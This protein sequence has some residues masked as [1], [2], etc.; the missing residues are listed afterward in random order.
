MTGSRQLLWL[1]GRNFRKSGTLGVVMLLSWQSGLAFERPPAGQVTGWGSTFISKVERGTGITN[2]ASG[3]THSLAITSRGTVACWG[4]NFNDYGYAILP[5][6]LSNVVAVG[7]GQYHS[8]A[9]RS[10]GTVV[11]WGANNDGQLMVP[12][13]LSNVVAI[14]VGA[15]DCLALKADGTVAAWGYSPD[16]TPPSG[17]S[18]V[19]AVA[20]GGLHSL[21]LLGDGTVTGWESVLTARRLCR[22]G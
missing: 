2:I 8:V 22:M 20:A 13:G 10:D 19:V 3:W 9:L 18:N 16:S 21:A 6:G 5:E 17:L 1:L 14:S 7:G 12:N 11:V 15:F 4:D